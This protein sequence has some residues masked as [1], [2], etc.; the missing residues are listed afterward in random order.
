MALAVALLGTLNNGTASTLASDSVSPS[1][2]SLLI[3]IGGSKDNAA[4]TPHGTPVTV[5][6]LT[7]VGSWTERA[8]QS[9]AEE[10][11]SY[12]GLYA[13]TAQ[14]TG[15]GGTG[16]ITIAYTQGQSG[17]VGAWIEVTGHNLS[18]PIRQVAEGAS[19]TATCAST[20]SLAPVSTSLLV[21]GCVERDSN[22]TI[23]VPT[24]WTKLD[25]LNSSSLC[26]MAVGYKLGSGATTN[27]WSGLGTTRN[28]SFV[29]EIPLASASKRRRVFMMG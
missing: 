23:T 10:S 20:F 6:G 19:T 8:G 15:A 29:L 28:F 2:S 27:T 13:H 11:G 5:S 14:V 16:T 4:P 18:S 17:L 21:G 22:N 25:E 3:G 12:A 24:G 26:Q 9:S 7:N 1:A